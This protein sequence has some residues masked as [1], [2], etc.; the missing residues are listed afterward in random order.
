MPLSHL[1]CVGSS[2]LSC[3]TNKKILVCIALSL[4]TFLLGECYIR[5]FIYSCSSSKV[6]FNW[7]FVVCPL[8]VLFLW[9]S[10]SDAQLNSCFLIVMHRLCIQHD[11]SDTQLIHFD[12]L[13]TIY[14]FEAS[15]DNSKQSTKIANHF[16]VLINSFRRKLR[17]SLY[18][19]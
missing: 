17:G 18:C 3:S 19:C 10:S 9:R 11:S 13:T 4:Q 12:I 6:K 16:E 5:F 15:S 1:N 8:T 2:K 7:S 14:S